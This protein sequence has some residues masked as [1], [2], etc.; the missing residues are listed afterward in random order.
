[1]SITRLHQDLGIGIPGDLVES[2]LDVDSDENNHEHDHQNCDL[3]LGHFFL[4]TLS[5]PKKASIGT[6]TAIAELTASQ[7]A[8]VLVA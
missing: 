5:I 3:E 6:P 4:N 7:K 8:L 2:K 1:M